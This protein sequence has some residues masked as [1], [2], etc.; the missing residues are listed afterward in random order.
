MNRARFVIIGAG[1]AGAATAYGLARR[2]VRDIIILER[3]NVVGSH[4]SGRNAALVRRNL[5]TEM[6]CYLSLAAAK[7]MKRPPADFPRELQFEETGSLL[8]FNNNESARVEKEFKI[9]QKAGLQFEQITSK[10]AKAIQPLLDNRAF[11]CAQWTPGDGRVDIVNLLFGYLEFA[12]RMGARIQCGVRVDSL[13]TNRGRCEGLR[14]NVG[15]F[16][17]DWI[18]NAAGGWANQMIQNAAP[19]VSMTPCRRTMLVTENVNADRSRPF[20]WDDG[21]SFYFREDFGGLLW[22]PC[23]E[24]PA[25]DC[26]QNVDPAWIERARDSA[27]QL[28][29][30]VANAKIN[31]QWA[32]L[33]T[34][35]FD[36]EMF[37]GPDPLLPQLFWVAGLGGH[38][39]TN[40]P[41]IAEIASDLLL[42]ETCEWIDP[43]RV[44]PRRP[45]R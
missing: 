10:E 32:C 45:S 13:I 8:L 33:R 24:T 37:I 14:T 1:V 4:A 9:Q 3:E 43:A 41:M 19:R 6:D 30:S 15:D 35:T 20:T 12:A 2:G 5:K 22:S 42:N 28:I 36:R 29:P 26:K 11:E 44:A 27:R 16:H 7:W 40:S 17:G 39:V 34:L 18:I 21:K 23:D 31:Y 38:G 25:E